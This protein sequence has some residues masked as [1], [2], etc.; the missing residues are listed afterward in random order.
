MIPDYA[1]PQDLNRYSYVRGNPVRFADPSGHAAECG[2]AIE[3]CGTPLDGELV[4]ATYRVKQLR[5]QQQAQRQAIIDSFSNSVK[6]FDLQ[7]FVQDAGTLSIG[8]GGNGFIA[9]GIRGG[10]AV[11]FD[12]HGNVSL[13][14]GGGSGEYT[15]AGGGW[16]FNFMV[17][18]APT[19]DQL[20]GNSVQVGG[21]VAK[22]LG[23][24]GELVIF[25]EEETIY[26]GINVYSVSPGD[27]EPW[28]FEIHGTFEHDK[29]FLKF[30]IFDFFNVFL[31]RQK[32]WK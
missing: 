28:P 11:N 31:A 18:N 30:N 8:F 13:T 3:D 14:G 4:T 21:S 29:T 12:T 1:N 2:I 26:Q 22:A 9:G 20:D 5:A 32:G 25:S 19:V 15:A 7:E 24:G 6:S 17:T 23:I 16:G 10:V 27:Y